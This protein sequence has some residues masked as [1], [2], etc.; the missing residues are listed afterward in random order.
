MS[1]DPKDPEEVLDFDLD[2]SARLVDGDTITSST[3]IIA[4]EPD[5]A[6]IN[7]SDASSATATKVWLAGGTLGA[8]YLLTNRVVTAGGRTM[9]HSEKL[10]I[11]AK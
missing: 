10:K 5:S 4:T 6:L 2:W 11:R 9:D 7:Q 1:W 3:W 8:T